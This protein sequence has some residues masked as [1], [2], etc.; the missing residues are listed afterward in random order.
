MKIKSARKVEVK[1][2]ALAA[3]DPDVEAQEGQDQ[4]QGGSTPGRRIT[5]QKEIKLKIKASRDEVD[6][7]E[8]FSKEVEDVRPLFDEMSATVRKMRGICAEKVYNPKSEAAFDELKGK[9]DEVA[10]LIRRKIMAHQNNE[11]NQKG[12]FAEVKGKIL[13]TLV[14]ELVVQTNRYKEVRSPSLS[15]FVAFVFFRSCLTARA[16]SRCWCNTRRT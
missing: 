3:L 11:K 13:A 16:M 7:F 9:V 4:D 8:R 14:N 1:Q 5:Q 12:P 2:P 10:G 15:F 6:E